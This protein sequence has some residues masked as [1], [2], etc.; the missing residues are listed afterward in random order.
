LNSASSDLYHWERENLGYQAGVLTIAGQQAEVMAHSA[1]APVFLYDAQRIRQ[2]LE[3]LQ[4][5]LAQ[6]GLSHSIYYAMK[7]NRFPPLLTYLRLLGRCGVD[8]CS[9]EELLSARQ[10]GFAETEISY[11]GTSV[12]EEDLAVLQRHP[13][14][15]I[16]CDSLSSIRRL[17]RRCPGRRIGLRI[18]PEMGLGYRMNR[19][20]QYAGRKA[21][22]FGIYHGQFKAALHCARESDLLVE[23]IHFHTGCGYLTPQLPLWSQILEA[24]QRF[25]DEC[26]DLRY[27]NLGGGLGIPLAEGDEPLDLSAWSAIISRQFGNSNLRICIEP[28]D[29][30]VK[31]AG[32]LVLQVNTVEEKGGTLFVGV[33]GGFNLHIEPAFYKL[34]LQVLPCRQPDSSLRRRVTIAGNINE[35]CDLLAENILLPPVHEGDY[36]AFLN[37]GGYGSSMSSNHCLRGFFREYLLP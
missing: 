17:G 2:N 31:D 30:L 8:V 18:N 14:V 36:L 23:G 19:L 22:K 6:A 10:V 9:P 26:P 5:V 35:A 29:Y 1:G 3:R 13:G 28:G 34:P 25:V 16:H 12:S 33:N 27:L 24:G 37:A 15:I 21:T 7:A 11:T 20:L 32:I 4:A